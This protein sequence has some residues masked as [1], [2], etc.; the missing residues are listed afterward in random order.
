MFGYF[1]S[2]QE[3]PVVPK[4]SQIVK[5]FTV[6]SIKKYERVYNLTK[7]TKEVFLVAEKITMTP[8]GIFDTLE[9]AKTEGKKITYHNCIILPFKINDKCKYL[10]T[11]AFEDK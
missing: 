10:Y 1:F 8:L 2:K 9:E 7:T 5:P 11:P 4:A 3:G 6:N